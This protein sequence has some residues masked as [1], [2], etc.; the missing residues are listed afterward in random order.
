M[1]QPRLAGCHFGRRDPI[2]ADDAAVAETTEIKLRP[3]GSL[4]TGRF[5][6]RTKNTLVRS[7]EDAGFEPAR[8]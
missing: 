7:A 6:D 4:R 5:H 8:A 1:P 2:A 3:L